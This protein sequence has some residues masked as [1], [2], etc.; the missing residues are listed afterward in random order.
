VLANA[1]QQVFDAI[2]ELRQEAERA[3]QTEQQNRNKQMQDQMRLLRPPLAELLTPDQIRTIQLGTNEEKTALIQS[4]DAEKR[5]RVFRTLG[6]RSRSGC[7]R[8][9]VAKRSRSRIHSRR[10]PTS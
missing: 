9:I 5:A 7:P 4:L 10:S 1:P 6:P 3:R 2:P 8:L